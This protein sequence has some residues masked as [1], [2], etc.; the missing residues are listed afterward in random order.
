M[1][2]ARV[3]R[4]L[5]VIFCVFGL[6]AIAAAEGYRVGPE[7]VLTIKV[8]GETSLSKD[9]EVAAD[10]SIRLP[11]IKDIPVKGLTPR[12][13]ESTLEQRLGEDYLVDP[14]V[15]VTVKE[16]KAQKVYILGSVKSPGYYTLRGDTRVLEAI[17]MAGGI[18]EEG[19]KEFI[20]IRGG[21]DEMQGESIEAL[22]AS[23][24]EKESIEDFTS[25]HHNVRVMRIDGYKLLESGDLT[26]NYALEAG[27]ILSVQ[28]ASFIYF[29]GEVKKPG[30]VPYEEGLTLL[31]AITLAG[32]RTDLGSNRVVITRVDD[33][34]NQQ[35]KVNLRKISQDLTKDF[36][37]QPGDIVK[38]RRSLF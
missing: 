35:F 8:F 11:W 34:K 1:R 7:D 14:Q 36:V 9:Y 20:L 30:P 12:E 32:G 17:A 21:A 5:L 26:Q 25:Q 10:G 31:K 27:D 24:G 18:T 13:I 28:K 29:D 16:Y 22:M 23:G 4:I 33:G 15:S 6:A 19:G 3:S 37:L 38:V 2:P